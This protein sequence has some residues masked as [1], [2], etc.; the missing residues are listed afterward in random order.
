MRAE[1]ASGGKTRRHPTVRRI[2]IAAVLLLAIVEPVV[3]YR[4]LMRERDQR[5]QAFAQTQ[6]SAP[7]AAYSAGR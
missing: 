1:S 3:M 2:V 5:Q 4:S 6:Q 7:D